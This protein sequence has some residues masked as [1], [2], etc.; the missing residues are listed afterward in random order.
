MEVLRQGFPNIIKDNDEMY[1]AHL[2]AVI[3][4]VD[5]Y[6]TMNIKF[7]GHCYH[8]RIA[9]SHPKYI[10]HILREVLKLNTLYGIHL[11]LS[12]SIKASSTI[13]FDIEISL[14]NENKKQKPSS[15]KSYSQS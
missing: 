7:M 9:P 15:K 1:F 11:E 5:E 14:Q 13:T 6:A 10:E 3:D 12:K 4:A 8:F 2:T